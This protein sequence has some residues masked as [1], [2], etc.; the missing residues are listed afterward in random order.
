MCQENA[1]AK[2][3]VEFTYLPIINYSMQQNGVSVVRLCTLKNQTDEDLSDLLVSLTPN[4][5][6]TSAA[7]VKIDFLAAHSNIK[8]DSLYLRLN[9]SFFIQLT[10]RV[11]ADITLCVSD[12]NGVL[13]SERYNLDVL[14]FDQWG[15]IDVLPEQLSAFVLP[16]NPC[17]S[18]IINRASSI[19]KE[20]TGSSSFDA[21]QSKNPNRV[22]K[23]MAAIYEAIKEL[24]IA[25]CVPPASF[26]NSGQRVRLVDSVV[27]TKLGTCLDMSL[28]YASC[29]EAIGLNPLI[30][31]IQEH[32]FAGGWLIDETF[33]DAV[34]DDPSLISK[35]TADGINEMVLVET[36]LM[37][38]GRD[39]SF[40]AASSAANAHLNNTDTFLLFLDVARCRFA[41]IR[42]L[43]QRV[44]KDDQY[45]V[46][47]EN[48]NE[49]ASLEKKNPEE[50]SRYELEGENAKASITKQLLWERKLLDLSMRNNLLNVRITKSTIQLI[51]ADIDK[52]E[53]TLSN[54]GEF[55]LLPK[56]SDWDNPLYDSGIYHALDTSNP[57]QELIKKELAQNRLRSYLVEYDLALS[58]THLYRSSRVSLEENGANTLYLALGWL[59]WFET[60]S[61]E[62][63]R[64]APILLLPVEIVRKPALRGYVIRGRGEESMLNITLL[65]MLRQN[66]GITISCL[67]PLPKDENGADVRLIFSIIRKMIMTQKRWDVEEQAML[68]TFSFS[69]FIMWNDIHSNAEVL[70]QNVIISSLMSGKMQW[71]ATE[72]DTDASELDHKLSP[73][74]VALPVSVDAS[75][76]EAVC[77]AVKGKS[78]ILHG[79]PGTGKSQTITNI[80]ANSLYNGKRV[81]FVAEKM[82]A[83]SVVQKRL[84]NI[85]LSPFCLELHSNK[86]NK[87]DVIL[88][89]RGTS[90]VSRSKVPEEFER[91]AQHLFRVRQQLNEYVENLH[92]VH[93]SGF[94]LYEAITNYFSLKDT[95]E[96]SFP[97]NLLEGLSKNQFY[98]WNEII[99]EMALE[100]RISGHPHD[101][102][103]SDFLLTEYSPQLK[104]EIDKTLSGLIDHFTA[105]KP[106]LSKCLEFF[107]MSLLSTE[108]QCKCFVELLHAI[109][110]IPILTSSLF[111][112]PNINDHSQNISEIAKQGKMRDELLSQLLNSFDKS[113]LELSGQQYLN[114]WKGISQ[115]WFLPR[116]LKTRKFIKKIKIYSSKATVTTGNVQSTLQM[117]VS[118]QQLKAEV[119]K[120]HSLLS[121]F[122]ES[123]A[124]P[125]R[126]NWSDVEK[127]LQSA[128]TIHRLLLKLANDRSEL[129]LIKKTFKKNLSCGFASFRELNKDL[130]EKVASLHSQILLLDGTLQATAGVSVSSGNGADIDFIEGALSQAHLW[131]DNTHRLKDAYRWQ[132]VSTKLSDAGL[133][134]LPQVYKTQH[135]PADQLHNLFLKGF[136]HCLAEYIISQKST[137]QLFKGEAFNEK[138][139]LFRELNTQYQSL[140][141]KELFAKLAAKVPSF[142]SEASQNSEVGILQKYIRSNGRGFSI[143][144]LFDSIPNLLPRMCPCMLMSPI[145]VAQYLDI[146]HEKFDLIVFDEASQ[147]PTSEAVGAISRGKNI[148]VVGDPKQMPPTSFFT[149]NTVDEENLELEDME[150]ILD[151]CL[152]LSMPSKYLLWH[153]RSKHESLIAFSNSQYYDNKL[154]TF[155]S[156]DN[157]DTRVTLNPIQ[158]YYDKGK[159]RQ[160]KAEARAVVDE[161]VRRLSDISLRKRSIGVVTFSSVQQTLIEDQLS[162]VFALNPYLEEVALN[163]EEPIF[164]K[165]LENVQGDERDIILF[166]VGYGPDENGRVS[167]N[168]GP[169]NR[170]GGERRL[171]VAVS[172][173]RY[174]MKVFSTLR[175]DQIDL[176]KTSA[177]G[178]AGLK[179]FLE[180]AE[181]GIPSIVNTSSQMPKADMSQIIAKELRQRG[182][183][184]ETQIGCSGFR[185]DIGIVNPKNPSTYL[186]GILCDGANYSIAK[187]ARDR[188]V[189]QSSV[190][191]MLGWNIHR[192]WTMDWWE[193]SQKVMDHILKA[194]D[195]AKHKKSQPKGEE[196]RREAPRPLLNTAL[197]APA[198]VEFTPKNEEEYNVARIPLF[199]SQ[200]EEFLLSKN[201]PNIL[202]QL[203]YVM[204][205]EAPISHAL[206]YKRIL[207]AWSISRLGTR[208]DAC[209]IS[210]LKR[211]PYHI[212]K[213]DGIVYYWNSKEEHDTYSKYRVNSERDVADLP[214]EEVANGM[215]AILEEQIALPQVDLIRLTA[216]LFGYGRTGPN[217]DVAMKRGVQLLLE[218][219]EIKIEDDKVSMLN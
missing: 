151:D 180:F 156:P 90:E 77:D 117:L 94:S 22:R 216:K 104:E 144:K 66:F 113:F 105:L 76:L 9:A 185:V 213:A 24:N 140:I 176:K 166:S 112:L 88:Q 17:L 138:V 153:Y 172:R 58:L 184:V 70:Q 126:E 118:Y 211:K 107:G 84:E 36:T 73:M 123:K 173:A 183:K 154:L 50:Y 23:Q 20:W 192:V 3:E 208:L 103:I 110:D 136:Y 132:L 111:M 93:P 146:T 26:E 27:S 133:N 106:E 206:L 130:F 98:E 210:L 51:S 91:E 48:K 182:F 149:T 175:A 78:F 171:N 145:S 196:M 170:D 39:V 148:I 56:P 71:A 16:N 37:N 128:Q 189:V 131:R 168:F 102:P 53:D 114:E 54:G 197:S 195:E 163:C 44:L 64:Y 159:S 19:L 190:L 134:F 87:S 41:K 89:L 18:L 29:V 86:T 69:K 198:V 40:D 202:K 125:D 150:S 203:D 49:S 68:G 45:I 82:A 30:I 178:V 218:R 191:K 79:P 127:T 1:L 52:L 38:D 65:E 186:L 55:Q 96:V 8:I 97:V 124:Q 43:P 28:L 141:K 85:G 162:D 108:E 129:S 158:G 12:A 177:K 81:L 99:Q 142:V 143:R 200:T 119:D 139:N 4:L 47:P 205:S 157:L 164:I 83:L 174:E 10:E 194:I 188:E 187:T 60:P 63:P 42:P 207:G 169:L 109:I 217:V 155:P 15:G 74:D 193:D 92:Q 161:I 147:M 160:N 95:D 34:N 61:S 62:R 7:S 13:Y 72:M 219:N 46:V 215:K 80:I 167:L 21:Y 5:E 31:I 115:C 212:T 181:K 101:N 179:S 122:F 2:L 32:A 33:S 6:F 11:L 100:G 59:K 204:R 165:N 75:Q 116:L 25:Y 209:L 120:N 199:G 57:M 67:D 35:R 214:P 137:L 135:L 121:S 14:A 152:T 201:E